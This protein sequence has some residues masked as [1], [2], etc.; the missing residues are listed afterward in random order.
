MIDT[1]R[2]GE[3]HREGDAIL[4]GMNAAVRW[5]LNTA[6]GCG[7]SGHRRR[8]QREIMDGGNGGR[9]RPPPARGGFHGGT[10]G[11]TERNAA[12]NW[13]KLT[14]AE[15]AIWMAATAHRRQARYTCFHLR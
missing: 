10:L 1:R 3:D 15:R 14:H 7:T 2:G 8:S 4:R 13:Q 5:S 11:E 9:V 6:L 12:R